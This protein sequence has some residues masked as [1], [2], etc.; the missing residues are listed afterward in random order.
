M[1]AQ[2]KNMFLEIHSLP[3]KHQK[4]ILNLHLEQWISEGKEQQMM[5]W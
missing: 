3:M 4:D 1:I 5:S 2:M